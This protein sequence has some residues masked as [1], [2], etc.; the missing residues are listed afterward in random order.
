MIT[1]SL[2]K[3][4]TSKNQTKT[5]LIGTVTIPVFF[6]E[7]SNWKFQN[8]QKYRQKKTKGLALLLL[9]TSRDIIIDAEDEIIQ[10]HPKK[11][12]SMK[13]RARR[14]TEASYIL[15]TMSSLIDENTL[16]YVD[17]NNVK[18]QISE[19]SKNQKDIGKI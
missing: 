1:L 8:G 12:D 7:Y 16:I 9:N 11:A 3:S 4:V 18:S 14:L 10:N 5:L 13:T 15:S 2:K 6:K 17:I 19:E